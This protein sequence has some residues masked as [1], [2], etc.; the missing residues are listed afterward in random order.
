MVYLV[1]SDSISKLGLSVRSLN[2]LIKSG[3]T[4][5]AEFMKLDMDFLHSIRNLGIKS[6]EEI[7]KLQQLSKVIA[8]KVS[9][10]NLTTQ[11]ELDCMKFVYSLVRIL[12]CHPGELFQILLPDFESAMMGG[13]PIGSESLMMAPFL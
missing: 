3:V 11:A 2:G 12:P 13:A 4:T 6:I 1:H 9:D 10:S 5:V 7:T 8:P